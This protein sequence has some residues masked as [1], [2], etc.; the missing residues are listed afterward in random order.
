MITPFR[1]S[2]TRFQTKSRRKL[3]EAGESLAADY[4]LRH[5]YRIIAANY[6]APIGH[7]AGGRLV[8]GEIDI[9]ALDENSAPPILCFVEVKTRT[10]PSGPAPPISSVDRR[11]QGR[12]ARTA[13]VFRRTLGLAGSPFRFD[14]VSITVESTDNPEIE[15]IRGP[16]SQAR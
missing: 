9:I 1:R 10:G 6:T 16:F 8:T 5:G 2:N 3:G 15:L 7:T 11:K 12:I 4:L 13:S 14:V